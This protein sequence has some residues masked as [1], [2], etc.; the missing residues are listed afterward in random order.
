MITC[1]KT[2]DAVRVFGTAAV[3][4]SMRVVGTLLTLSYTLFFVYVGLE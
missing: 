2:S 1:L 3:M 4:L